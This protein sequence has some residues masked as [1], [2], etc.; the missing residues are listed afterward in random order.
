MEFTEQVLGSCCPV[1]CDDCRLVAHGSGTLAVL[2]DAETLDVLSEFECN[3]AV[4]QARVSPDGQYLL[5]I[6][7]KGAAAYVFD[8]TPDSDFSCMLS[9]GGGGL[10]HARWAPSSRHILTCVSSWVCF[11]A[12]CR[13]H[14]ESLIPATCPYAA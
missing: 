12:R 9:E 5:C 14:V 4:A 13:V 3:G 2:R 8:L 1:F 11:C 7:K 6:L 10:A